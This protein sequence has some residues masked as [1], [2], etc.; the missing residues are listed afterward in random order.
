VFSQ[1][2]EKHDSYPPD[3]VPDQ[4]YGIVLAS[5]K[6]TI[7]FNIVLKTEVKM[8][9]KKIKCWY[10]CRSRHATAP[11]QKQTY[12]RRELEREIEIAPTVDAARGESEEMGTN[13]ASQARPWV[14]SA[15]LMNHCAQLLHHLEE[16]G[17]EIQAGVL[18]GAHPR[19]LIIRASS[20][21]Q[22]C[23]NK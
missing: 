9:E 23:R 17:T 16:L 5:C 13:W 10:S 7:V 15:A 14:T 20:K 11:E 3:A 18:G 6:Y 4:L 2:T 22:L 19:Y 1:Q 8:K 21:D 12:P